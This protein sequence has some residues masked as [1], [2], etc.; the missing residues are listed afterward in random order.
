MPFDPPDTSTEVTASTCLRPENG[1][2]P[3][4]VVHPAHLAT[5]TEL[6]RVRRQLMAL[7]VEADRRVSGWLYVRC[8]SACRCDSPD[9]NLRPRATKRATM[10]FPGRNRD[11][12]RDC[13]ESEN[14]GESLFGRRAS[15]VIP[16]ASA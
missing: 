10:L 12:L 14:C 16:S 11:T 13:E 8:P 3:D 15:L 9:R 1:Y 5:T 6:E 4:Q 2:G 7:E